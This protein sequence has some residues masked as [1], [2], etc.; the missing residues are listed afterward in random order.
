[1][2][3]FLNNRR[4]RIAINAWES[5]LCYCICPKMGVDERVGSCRCSQGI[6]SVPTTITQHCSQHPIDKEACHPQDSYRIELN[7]IREHVFA[8][9]IEVGVYFPYHAI[10]IKRCICGR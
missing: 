7:P 8:M 1:M 4:L 6:D 10:Y 3:T 5:V 2:V 9:S